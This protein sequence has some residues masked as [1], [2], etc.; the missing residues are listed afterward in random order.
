[1]KICINNACKSELEDYVERCPNCGRLQKQLFFE[2]TLEESQDTKEKKSSFSKLADHIGIVELWLCAIIAGN[3]LM[4]FMNF[5]PKAMWGRNY[6]DELIPH[7]IIAGLFCL[8]NV[9]GAIML[10]FHRKIGFT[11]IALSAIIGGIFTFVTIRSLP[12]GIVGIVVL[13]YVLKIK[14][15]GIP[16]W[17]SLK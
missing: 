1:M 5:N 8:L 10:L 3:I 2:K 15:N 6:P 16:Y 9:F 13:W 4:A 14:K 17:D 12:V 11:T 7:S